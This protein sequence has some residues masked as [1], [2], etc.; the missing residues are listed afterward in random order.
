MITHALL[1]QG[2]RA[3]QQVFEIDGWGSS[4]RRHALDLRLLDAVYWVAGLCSAA[5]EAI[6]LLATIRDV[7]FPLNPI[8]AKRHFIFLPRRVEKFLGDHIFFPLHTARF[9]PTKAVLQSTSIPVAQLVNNVVKRLCQHNQD[10]LNPYPKEARFNYRVTTVS[11]PAIKAFALPGG[12]M[13]VGSQ[14]VKQLHTCILSREIR[15]SSIPLASG[16]VVKVDLSRV[17][18]EDAL[19]SL[20]GHEMTHIASR[21]WIQGCASRQQEEYEADVTGAYLAHRAG[22]RSVGALYMQEFL[23]RFSRDFG[24]THPCVENRKRAL[25]AAIAA[26]D[27]QSLL[28]IPKQPA[29]LRA[30]L[31]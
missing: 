21:H 15:E 19:A 27:P 26:F 10:L 8:N 17:T 4:H 24:Y 23:C 20:V 30:L 11:S 31:S 9:M 2:Q 12:S 1:Y 7:V 14:L 29:E 22:Y 5:V 6:P 25:F 18:L 28:F 3:A 13:V 16:S